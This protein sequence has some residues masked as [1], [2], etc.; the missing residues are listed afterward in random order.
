MN[1]DARS[2][3]YAPDFNSLLPS[4]G[5]LWEAL[6]DEPG[7]CLHSA[8]VTRVVIG[9]SDPNPSSSAELVTATGTTLSLETM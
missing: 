5:I 3:A 4:L 1:H 2:Y 6:G 9:L 8:N 7:W